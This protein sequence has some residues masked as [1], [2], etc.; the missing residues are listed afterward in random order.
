MYASFTLRW[1]SSRHE[2]RV[3]CAAGGGWNCSGDVIG[4]SV[5]KKIF[6]FPERTVVLATVR[7]GSRPPPSRLGGDHFTALKYG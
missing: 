1:V 7:P 3:I 5:R 4:R 6:N 2:N